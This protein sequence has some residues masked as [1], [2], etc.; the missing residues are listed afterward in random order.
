MTP[1]PTALG[2]LGI[3]KKFI[4]SITIPQFFC[5]SEQVKKKNIKNRSERENSSS[6]LRQVKMNMDLHRTG[7]SCLLK[8][9]YDEVTVRA[10]GDETGFALQENFDILPH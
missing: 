5:R 3:C 1:A 8:L 2:P 6:V 7:R 10:N 4:S 9:Q